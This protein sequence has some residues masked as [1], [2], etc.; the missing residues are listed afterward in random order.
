M[1]EGWRL[2]P[3]AIVEQG[4]VAIGDEIGAALG[5]QL[6][7]VLS[8]NAR[9]Q[10]ARLARGLLHLEPQPGRTDAERNCISNIRIGGL[11]Y[12][13]AA[14]Q[15]SHYMTEARRRQLTGIALKESSLQHRQP[16][17]DRPP[18]PGTA[19]IGLLQIRLYRTQS[20]PA[21]NRDRPYACCCVD[22]PILRQEGGPRCIP[23][24]HRFGAFS[25][26]IRGI[27]ASEHNEEFLSAIAPHS[28]IWPDRLLK[29]D[30]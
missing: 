28:I 23:S 19:S 18:L 14:V 26:K 11:D 16:G 4:R 13:T 8:A 10:F 1:L 30:G 21:I 3:L 12:F 9:T 24:L 20:S 27:A 17:S 29:P 6:S 5:T 22:G 7:V 2:A 15:L 25:L